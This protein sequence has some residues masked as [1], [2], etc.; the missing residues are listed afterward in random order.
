MEAAL[1]PWAM[2]TSWLAIA[3]WKKEKLGLYDDTHSS[4]IHNMKSEVYWVPSEEKKKKIYHTL[5][6]SCVILDEKFRSVQTRLAVSSF[7]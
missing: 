1:Y 6:K 4:I 7:E 5:H 3:R 2:A